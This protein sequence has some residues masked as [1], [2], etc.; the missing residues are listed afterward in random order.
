MTD[1]ELLR[2]IGQA[3]DKYIMESRRRPK[4]RSPIRRYL[5]QLVAAC[6]VL[7]VAGYAVSAGM[8]SWRSGSGSTSE[9]TS[10]AAEDAPAEA[11]A[12]AEAPAEEIEA[13]G[14]DPAESKPVSAYDVTLLSS[15]QYPQ[16]IADTDYDGLHEQWTQNVVSDDTYAS[17]QAFS[18][19]TAA[20]ALQNG[21]TSGCFSPLSLYQALAVLTDGAQGQTQ[22]ELLSLLGMPDLDTL[23]E[24]SSLLYRR[25]YFDNDMDRLI[26]SNS[27]WLDET[28]SDGTSIDYSRDWVMNAAT[29]YYA[30]VYQA[31]FSQPDTAQAMGAWIAEKTGGF[32]HP[33][34]DIDDSTVMS[35]VNTVWYKS[36]WAYQFDAAETTTG[37]F[38]TDSGEVVQAEYMHKTSEQSIGFQTEEYTKGE[39]AMSIGHMVFVL[40]QEGVD[41]DSLLTEEK[42]WEI[43]GRSDYDSA[44]MVWSIPKF[45]TTVTYSLGEALTDL[46][47]TSAFRDSADFSGISD[48][49]LFVSQVRQ[50]THISLNEDGV[51][52]AAYTDMSFAGAEPPKE[53]PTIEM[54]LNRPFIY[55]ITS[56]DGSPLF[57]GVVRDPAA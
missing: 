12:P 42:L 24:Q 52:A 10:A 55:M 28:T 41:V 27:L 53:V 49:P 37:D 25:N 44:D 6:L 38:T 17:V 22:A 15:A 33:T 45:E 16:A 11:E 5:P 48:T 13:E 43:F 3:D 50:G 20:K 36:Q 9:A 19:A 21:E 39:I 32:L 2:Y 54:N 8:L 29:N 1:F 23:R 26:I 56:R 14:T 46:G 47:V 34:L 7:C 35:I 31:E 4:K 18:F 51:E 57:I 40:P 30:D